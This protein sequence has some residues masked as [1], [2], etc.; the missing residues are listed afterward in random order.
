MSLDVLGSLAFSED[1]LRVEISCLTQPQL[2][3]VDLPGLI[4][5]ENRKQSVCNVSLVYKLVKSYM[6]S[7][8]SIIL[9]VISAM[10]E[11]V[12]QI[13]LKKTHDVDSE[14]ECTI[15]IIIK[16]DTLWVKTNSEREFLALAWN[17]DVKFKH[18]WHVVKNLDLRADEGEIK[19]RD[20]EKSLFFEK[21]NFKSLSSFSIEISS[22]CHHLSQILFD[23]IWFKLLKLIENIQ[24]DIATT[25]DELKKLGPSHVTPE[26]QRAFLIRVS[27]E[28][29]ILL[30]DAINDQYSNLFFKNHLSAKRHLCAVIVNSHDDFRTSLWENEAWWIILKNK[31]RKLVQGD[32]SSRYHTWEE[33]I[34]KIQKL[35][36]IS[37]ER[38]I[39]AYLILWV[40]SDE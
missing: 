11:F 28:F 10:N 23:Q 12:N 8:R 35:L 33:V 40:A 26:E 15:D 14:G 6:N 19:D 27:Q 4:H 20:S 7:E 5:S 39:I 25:W 1:I 37:H 13:V 32:N 34:N 30:K 36:C 17:E 31:G 38:E 18:S 3:V 29:Q 22:L 9:T 21:S 2:T 16:P 24:S